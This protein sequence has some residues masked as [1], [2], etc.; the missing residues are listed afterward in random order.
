MSL[1]NSIYLRLVSTG[2]DGTEELCSRAIGTCL[3]GL[4]TNNDGGGRKAGYNGHR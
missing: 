4:L 2:P 3:A 1:A